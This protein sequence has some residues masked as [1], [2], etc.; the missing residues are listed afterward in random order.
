MGTT[1][2]PARP[3]AIIAFVDGFWQAHGYGPSLPQIASA[4]GL[5]SRSACWYRIRRL[6]DDGRM[7]VAIE[8][9]RMVPRTW[10]VAA[11]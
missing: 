4:V 1:H 8:G 2:D 11:P 6:V 3:D 9:E 10:K 7:T 5:K